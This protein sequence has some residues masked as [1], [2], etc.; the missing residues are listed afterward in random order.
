MTL[1]Q[2]L[3]TQN[4]EAYP[5]LD[6]LQKGLWEL[7]S[8]PTLSIEDTLHEL[9][10]FRLLNLGDFMEREIEAGILELAA[11]Y[12]KNPNKLMRTGLAL[13]EMVASLPPREAERVFNQ[14]LE[15]RR[16]SQGKVSIEELKSALLEVMKDI[17]ASHRIDSTEIIGA[18][19]SGSWAC[20]QQHAGSN[21]DLLLVHRSESSA[22]RASEYVASVERRL[23]MKIDV[24]GQYVSS[25]PDLIRELESPSGT[26][27]G[28]WML[29]TPFK[30]VEA[31]FAPRLD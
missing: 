30:K 17:L 9:R 14:E 31:L 26:A 16:L 4:V 27:K 1:D 21:L 2:K 5:T 6:A 19:V 7:A 3:P 22:E 10:E 23:G 15:S 20:G 24:R 12:G 29:I 25:S 13:I 18:V 8:A 11:L 28:D